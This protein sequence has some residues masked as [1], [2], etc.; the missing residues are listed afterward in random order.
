MDDEVAAITVD[1]APGEDK[2]A[3][4]EDPPV[5]SNYAQVDAGGMVI[6]IQRFSSLPPVWKVCKSNTKVGS[7][8]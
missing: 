2:S 3:F 1:N 8:Y 7:K 4:A 5:Y 6:D